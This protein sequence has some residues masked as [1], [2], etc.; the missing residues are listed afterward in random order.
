MK[1]TKKPANDANEIAKF[2]WT[3]VRSLLKLEFIIAV[4]HKAAEETNISQFNLKFFTSYMEKEES[5]VPF[6]IILPENKIKS[7]FDFIISLMYFYFAFIVPFRI[8]FDSE[9][10]NKLV[11]Y[12]I[13]FDIVIFI[14]ICLTFFT[15]YYDN[16]LLVID[17]K[18]ISKRYVQDRFVADFIAVLPF[19]LI[20]NYFY[21][22]KISRVLR[23]SLLLK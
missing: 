5:N 18:S 15:A 22:L 13:V 8:C 1:P 20:N 14:D 23:I 17:L 3:K 9:N 4:A 12:D 19:Y 11:E 21:W 2:R 6:Y 7:A 10:D 16:S